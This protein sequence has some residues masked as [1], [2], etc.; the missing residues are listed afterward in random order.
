MPRR[1]LNLLVLAAAL[2]AL[3]STSALAQR[4]AQA[5]DAPGA[6]PAASPPTE[7]SPSERALFVADHLANLKPPVSLRYS[8]LK[9][10]SLEEGFED[11][12]LV[13]VRRN[14]NGCCDADAEFLTGA[15]RMPL[16]PVEGVKGNPVLLY[17]LERDIREMNRL[18]KGQAAYF[19]KRIRMA[20]FQGAEVSDIQIGYQ[21]RQVAAQRIVI[22]PYADDPLRVR[23]EKLASKQYTFVLSKQVPGE[24]AMLR[25]R[26]ADPD[27]GKPPVLVERLLL[28]GVTLPASES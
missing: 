9:G 12:V 28:E 20:V 23:F 22:R 26:V 18:T 15:R 16:P 13:K 14:G 25:A 7:F 27:A 21:G 4:L 2:S 24:I 10:G 17:F 3:T 5:P 11:S 8:Y 6:A 1:F 19:R